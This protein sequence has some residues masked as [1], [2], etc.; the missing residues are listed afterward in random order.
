MSILNMIEKRI[1]MQIE[2]I[3]KYD[4]KFVGKPQATKEGIGFMMFA[5]SKI[6][7]NLDDEEIEEGVV[8][9]GYRNEQHDYGIDALYLTANNEVIQS[10]DE[11]KS[12]NNDTKFV[13]HIFQFKKGVG[14]DQATLLKLK[15][16]IKET[17]INS[18]ILYDFNKYMY[19]V[20]QNIY[21]MREHIY[22]EFSSSQVHIKVY[23]CFSGVKENVL[24][25][26][27]VSKQLVEIKEILNT[28][29]YKN[30]EICLVDAQ[31]LIDAERDKP[32]IKDIIAYRKTFKYITEAN[33]SEKLNGYICVVNAHEIARLVK[34]WQNQLFEANI[35]D[36]FQ[37]K[38][39]NSKIFDTCTDDIE[40]KYF[41]SYNNG[42]TITCNKV[43][44]L[45]NDKYKLHGLQI[46]N[47]CQTS[48]TL[49][50]ALLNS[51][52]YEDL[53]SRETLSVK[54]KTE[55][56]NLINKRL[57]EEATVLV[58]IIE[59]GNADLIYRITE[60]TNS[61]TPIKVF[62][63]KANEDIHKNIEQF[64]MDYGVYYERRANFFKNQG[65]SSQKIIDIKKLA[66]LYFAMIQFKPSQARANPKKVFITYYDD[67]FPNL[68]VKQINYKL[69]LVP[70]LVHLKIEK[71]IRSILKYDLLGI[72]AYK[73]ALLGNGKFHIGCFVLS[74][75]LKSNYNDKGIVEQFKSIQSVLDDDDLFSEHFENAVEVFRKT[76][77][78]YAGNKKESV[79]SALRKAEFDSRI[80]RV[81]KNNK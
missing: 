38:G 80:V 71:H 35:R 19:E 4:E 60:T 57:N 15:E 11:L 22:E 1:G 54:E 21:E 27:I 69:F 48:N 39:N 43:E 67:I 61:Q 10:P 64:F 30:V 9:S 81:I 6:M 24:K 72:D 52:R 73:R 65:V 76:I 53:S 70:V 66:Q 7:S 28:N 79:P 40:G 12:Y 14:I 41:W 32:E 31:E 45:P 29:A 13:F 62:S 17:F 56:D 51:E 18:N 20:Y 2:N 47:G 77:Q 49:Y 5:L 58:K 74:S 26:E 42:L 68:N 3:S 46:V 55:L 59:T 50:E 36:Y 44:E 23:I 63:L 16:G 78:S 33:E 75:I 37:N 8:D 25:D 34:E